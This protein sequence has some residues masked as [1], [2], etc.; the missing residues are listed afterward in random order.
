MDNYWTLK[1]INY[2]SINMTAEE[3][4]MMEQMRICINNDIHQRNT[5][6]KMEKNIQLFKYCVL[7]LIIFILFNLFKQYIIKSI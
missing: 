5:K 2:H 3:R 7:L 4:E 6:I 1:E